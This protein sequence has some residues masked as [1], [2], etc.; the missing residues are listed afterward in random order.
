MGVL[1]INS[2]SSTGQPPIAI[3]LDGLYISSRVYE[4]SP[5]ANGS[6][7]GIGTIGDGVAMYACFSPGSA[8][9]PNAGYGT[10]M[11]FV[12]GTT[13]RVSSPFIYLTGGVRTTVTAISGVG[14]VVLTNESGETRRL[15]SNMFYMEKNA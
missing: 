8:S 1:K 12:N 9:F 7:I 15:Y 3:A 13:A 11:I 5:I 10:L 2:T 4:S 6:T 14:D